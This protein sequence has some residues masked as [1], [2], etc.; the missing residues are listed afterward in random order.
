[1]K[2]QSKRQADRDTLRPHYDFR[3]GVRGKYVSRYRAGTKVVV[4]D[5]DVAAAFPTAA[6]VNRALRTLMDVVRARPA[7]RRSA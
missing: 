7:R 6:A 3:G 1:M 2:K 4:L 5:P